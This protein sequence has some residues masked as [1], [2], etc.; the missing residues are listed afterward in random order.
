MI[1]Q[2]LKCFLNVGPRALEM[3]QAP[4]YLNPALYL[5]AHLAI[6]AR[7]LLSLHIYS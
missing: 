4:H 6:S 7:I 5:C 1:Q 3:L 2:V